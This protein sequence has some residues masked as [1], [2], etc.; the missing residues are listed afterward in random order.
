MGNEEE[1]M[2]DGMENLEVKG[3]NDT[4]DFEEFE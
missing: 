3:E 1:E 2:I 4:I